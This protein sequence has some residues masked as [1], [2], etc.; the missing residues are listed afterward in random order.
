MIFIDLKL[1]F[2]QDEEIRRE[3]RWKRIEI[4]RE[5]KFARLRSLRV[6]KRV[7]NCALLRA[8]KWISEFF[9]VPMVVFV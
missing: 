9:D 2:S 7:T 1:T 3:K 6:K 5:K 4:I 8:K